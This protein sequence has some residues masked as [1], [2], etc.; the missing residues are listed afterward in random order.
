MKELQKQ[1]SALEGT[2]QEEEDAANEKSRLTTVGMNE[3]Q[4]GTVRFNFVVFVDVGSLS[5]LLKS[6]V[7]VLHVHA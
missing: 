2:T 5:C 1:L 6:H 3:A 7:S 4:S